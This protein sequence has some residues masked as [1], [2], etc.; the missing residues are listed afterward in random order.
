MRLNMNVRYIASSRLINT[1]DRTR[2]GTIRQD[3]AGNLV[4]VAWTTGQ[5]EVVSINNLDVA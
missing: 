2:T 1:I 3:L 4:E 5:V